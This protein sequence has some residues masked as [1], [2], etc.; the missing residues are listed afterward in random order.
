MTED[1]GERCSNIGSPGAYLSYILEP[2]DARHDI[3]FV[4]HNM[5]LR[6]KVHSDAITHLTLHFVFICC[7]G[8]DGN[9]L[10]DPRLMCSGTQDKVMCLV[11]L[12]RIYAEWS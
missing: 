2:D 10:M 4:Y 12:T 7:A 6:I 5:D 8:W 1:H 3:I 11:Y 9:G